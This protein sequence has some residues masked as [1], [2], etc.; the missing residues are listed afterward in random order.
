M[1]LGTEDDVADQAERTTETMHRQ[2]AKA[3]S[4]RQRFQMQIKS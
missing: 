3:N 1:N 4:T 2:I